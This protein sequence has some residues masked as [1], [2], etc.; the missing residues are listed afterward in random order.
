M[1]TE[2]I[3][4]FI[5]RKRMEKG[6]TQQELGNIL[7]VSGKAV[8]KW[9]RGLS[10]PDIS[11]L[12]QLADVLDTDI[13]SI[14]QIKKKDNSN[15][16]K[17]LQEEKN[18]LKKQL[19]KKVIFLLIIILIIIIIFLYKFLPFGYQLKVLEYHDK[20][21]NLGIPAYSF[22]LKNDKGSF[23]YKNFRN[24]KVLKTEMKNY[25]NYL[26]HLSCN[27]TTYYYDPFTDISI[28]NYDVK[29]HIFYN[30]IE[31]D[32]KNGNYCQTLL[33]ENYQKSLGGL[34]KMFNYSSLD[35]KFT[36]SFYPT[37]NHST[38]SFDATMMIREFNPQKKKMTIVESSSGSFEIVDDELIYTRTK[39]D[40][41]TLTLSPVSKFII[42]KEK[43]ILKDNYLNDYAI[44][45]ILE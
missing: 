24:Q 12:E 36:V 35:N 40:K 3:G 6:L 8:S 31:Y 26:D 29:S 23:S 42:K 38:K 14:L 43:L 19:V 30:T 27:N 32:I 18:N 45:I 10:I 15:I 39:I 21:I 20:T 13:Y 37:Y 22:L 44:E 4:E 11:L 41:S 7:F 5:K 34:D 33:I 28:I 25:L 1:D 9:E 17:I 16:K 2:K